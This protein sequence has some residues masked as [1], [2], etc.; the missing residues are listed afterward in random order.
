MTEDSGDESPEDR[1]YRRLLGKSAKKGAVGVGG[2]PLRTT[3]LSS[4]KVPLDG[5]ID[6]EEGG[7]RSP[8]NIPPGAPGYIEPGST[9]DRSVHDKIRLF[10]Q[11]SASGPATNHKELFGGGRQET[12]APGSGTDERQ[13]DDAVGVS[14]PPMPPP[15]DSAVRQARS[16]QGVVRKR[17]VRDVKSR[18]R[19]ADGKEGPSRTPE[20][21]DSAAGPAILAKSPSVGLT[22]SAEQHDSIAARLA[23]A[24]P[25][26]PKWMCRVVVTAVEARDVPRLRGEVMTDCACRVSL[27]APG[28]HPVTS[29]SRLVRSSGHDKGVKWKERMVFGVQ[30]NLAPAASLDIELVG[31]SVADPSQQVTFGRVRELRVAELLDQAW[32]AGWFEVMDSSGALLGSTAMRL[33]VGFQKREDAGDSSPSLPAIQPSPSQSSLS[34]ADADLLEGPESDM[35][36]DGTP[37]GGFPPGG[38]GAASHN[39]TSTHFSSREPA[40][41]P[42]ALQ[43]V[44]NL[45][46]ES[47]AGAKGA[48]VAAAAAAAVGGG[49]EKMSKAVLAERAGEAASAAAAAGGGEMPRE[50]PEEEQ[51]EPVHDAAAAAAANVDEVFGAAATGSLADARHPGDGD[52]GGGGAGTAAASGKGSAGAVAAAGEAA[53]VCGR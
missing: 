13:P 38:A 42:L 44:G 3:P 19:S 12:R 7:S 36:L 45:F 16:E 31:R 28:A 21:S 41:T 52:A 46:S 9:P 47:E 37:R 4:V 34:L 18:G 20:A 39:M 2:T 17:G 10:H 29:T 26:P 22:P 15:G 32:L 6:G 24:S 43:S 8:L 53:A 35:S 51:K 1:D 50:V 14:K 40:R 25:R 11:R 23:V 5:I 30:E 27:N 33:T 48:E 49:E